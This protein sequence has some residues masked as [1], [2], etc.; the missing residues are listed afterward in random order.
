[1]GFAAVLRFLVPRADHFY[2]FLERQAVVAHDGAVALS[3]FV[4]GNGPM[5][6]DAVQDF[7][8]RGDSI[9]HEMEEALART[10]VTPIDREDLHSLST[11]IDDILDLTNGAARACALFGIERPSEA[12]TKLMEVLVKSTEV[13]KSAMPKLRKHAYAEIMDEVKGIKALEKQGDRIYRDAVS[14]LFRDPAIDAK[15]LLR[16]KGVL[17]DLE[18]A[19][20][21]CEEA[22]ERLTNLSVKH[23]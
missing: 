16:E 15:A 13:L 5:V 21:S 3:T 18:N 7:E 23:G 17:E 22:A 20:D 2:T 1:M 19:I 11:T 6:C 9:V 4:E 12:M 8:H 14:A 10:F